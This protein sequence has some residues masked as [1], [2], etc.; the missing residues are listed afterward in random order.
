M[1]KNKNNQKSRCCLKCLEK[2]KE[3][4]KLNK[5]IKNNDMIRELRESIIINNETMIRNIKNYL[6]ELLKNSNEKV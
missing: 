5:I 3:I 6:Q 4:K 2:E 1:I